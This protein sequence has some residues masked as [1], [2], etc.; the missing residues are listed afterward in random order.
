MIFGFTGCSD[1]KG[2]GQTTPSNIKNKT[3]NADAKKVT[4]TAGSY[5]DYVIPVVEINLDDLMFE[6]AFEIE[7]RAKGEGHTFWWN[8]EEYTT[9]LYIE[10]HMGD[11]KWVR[12]NN[13]LDDYCNTNIWDECGVCNGPGIT[14]WYRDYDGDGL[15]DPEWSTQDCFYPSVDEE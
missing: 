11:H 6:D 5:E 7:H 13:D 10:T 4:N 1:A 9:D 8:G 14:I 15:G 2:G 3:I 12:N